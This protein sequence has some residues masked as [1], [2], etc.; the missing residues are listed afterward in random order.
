MAKSFENAL[1]YVEGEGLK[2]I[3]LVFDERIESIGGELGK[4]EII[5]LPENAV[6]LPGFIDEHIH[7]AGGADAMDGSTEALKTI[8]ETV[9][10]E[11][12]TTF[13]ATTMTQSKQNILKAMKAVRKYREEN[14]E[15]G[16]RLLGVHLEG[17]FIAAAHKGAQPLEY[18]AK[19]DVK[20][21]DEYNSASGDAIK[22]VTMAPEEDGAEELVRHLSDKGIIPSVG[23]TG[24]TCAHIRSAIAAGAKN[25]THTYNAQSPLHH[26][27]IGTVGSAL[28]YDELNCELI[29]DTIHVSVPAIQLLVKC[30]HKDK[31][32]LITDAMRAKGLADGE[33]ELGGQVV[34]VKNGEARL[35]DGTL[36]GSVLRMNRAIANLVEKVGV[37]FLQ[38]VDYATI[39]P[40]RTLGIDG[41]TGS[42]RVGKRADFVVLDDKFS[43][44]YTIRDGKIVY[45]AEKV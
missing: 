19:P 11:G 6:V 38:A 5:P 14:H 35:K 26:R 25:V 31:L 27:E 10:A 15:E 9:A 44:L 4:S 39:N 7:G 20:T 2:K 1:V 28:L 40:A 37:A 36:A 29:A 18:V 16:A 41:E 23:H 30:K 22:I 13:L 32:T 43:V 34:I 33:S 24:A 42:I 17:P 12:T 8:A 45:R 3:N 21:F